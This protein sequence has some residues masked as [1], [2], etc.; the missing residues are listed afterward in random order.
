MATVTVV[1]PTALQATAP[2]VSLSNCRKGGTGL[3]PRIVIH[4]HPAVGKTSGARPA[5]RPLFLMSPGETGLHT[6]IHSGQ[7]PGNIPNIEVPD[8]TNMI[9]LLQELLT[10]KHGGKTLVIDVV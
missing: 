4:R 2:K 6:L 10:A 3:P 8:W 1:Q 5:P 9:G 7:L